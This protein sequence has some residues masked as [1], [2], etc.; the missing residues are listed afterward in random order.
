M[1][2]S[3]WAFVACVLLGTTASAEDT[4]IELHVTGLQTDDGHVICT[5]YEDTESWL[6]SD[7]Y[8][9][10][11]KARP[12]DG[13]AVCV[14]PSIP[15]GTYAVSFIHDANDDG[16]LD[17]NFIG[18]PREPWGVSQD[19]PARLGAPSFEAA[20]FEHP[21]VEELAATVR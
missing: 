9:A 6:S 20:S 1:R 15:A 19:A 8:R 10:T 12:A 21:G 11:T 3:V 16:A 18:I 7:V 4:A 5:L 2:A 14:F 13:V 17:K